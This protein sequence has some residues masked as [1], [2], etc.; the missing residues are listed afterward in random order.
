MASSC[1]LLA[2][3]TVSN[4]KVHFLISNAIPYLHPVGAEQKLYTYTIITTDSNQQ[5]KFLH[6]RMPVI[7]ENG[8]DQIRTWL[9]PHRSQWS[10]E[11][12]S[13]LKPFEG[14]LEC[15]PVSKEVGKVGNDSPAFII[16]VA[17]REN[18]GNIANFFSNAKKSARGTEEKEEIKTE[19]AEITGNEGKFKQLPD[20]RPTVEQARSE[21]NA[22]IPAPEVAHGASHL[23]RE[24]VDSP[25]NLNTPVAKAVKTEA[26]SA[27]DNVS[28]VKL[29]DK[30]TRATGKKS[31]SAT[32]NGTAIKESAA[33]ASDGSQRITNFFGK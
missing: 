29:A 4:S 19:K 9:D 7:L 21:D 33:K 10:R 16:P 18:K 30:T 27:G 3:G 31:R 25:D 15:Y 28:P 24:R 11:L 1:A 32:C 20:N 8:S 14:E 12:Q 6:N 23:K 17:S 2:C 22:P 26:N 5:L 13:L